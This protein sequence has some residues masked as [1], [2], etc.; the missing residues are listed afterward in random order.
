MEYVDGEDLA[1]LLRRIGR[2]P[3]DKAIE[4][5]RQVCAGLQAAHDR[6]VVHRDLKPANVMIDGH[7]RAR[8]TDFG[9]AVVGSEAAGEVAGT[10]AYM[11][12][13]QF[14]GEPATARTDLWA[15][16]CSK[17]APANDPSRVAPSRIGARLH[18]SGLPDPPRQRARDIDPALERVILK[19]LQKEP[20][21]R[22]ASASQVALALPGGDPL[23]AALAAGETP[24]PPEMVAA[25]PLRAVMSPSMAIGGVA[26]ALALLLVL[27]YGSRFSALGK[28][29]FE[30]AA[31][32]LADRA[33]RVITASFD[34][35]ATHA[36]PQDREWGFVEELD[37]VGWEQD[38]LPTPRRWGRLATRPP[39]T[40]CSG[41]AR[42]GEA[43]SHSVGR[44][45]F[46]PGASLRV[47]GE[48]A[49]RLNL[50]G[51]LVEL[52]RVAPAR[53]PSQPST[54]RTRTSSRRPGL[55]C[56]TRPASSRGHSGRSPR[57]GARPWPRPP[58]GPGAAPWANAV[59]RVEAAA[60]RGQAVW[61][62]LVAPWEALRARPP[63]SSR[64][65]R[66]R[67][68]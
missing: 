2:L 1:T 50:R 68:A 54:A 27:A 48:A 32:A 15:C 20:A 61:F 53:I 42:P 33:A 31:E 58:S 46:A 25:S 64:S 3:Q 62:R 56:S 7:G 43:T 12:P 30:L 19:C 8:I 36:K 34:P 65:L 24:V 35:L 45:S 57:S 17:S 38:P 49:V 14:A 23:A 4:I 52:L 13:E 51:R 39:P 59:L 44:R 29:P 22:P 6:G 60:F 9:L 63:A 41:T 5:A 67:P 47:E 66:R 18:T 10:P 21:R 55:V 40:T 11:A 28:V 16:C 37:Y 26:A